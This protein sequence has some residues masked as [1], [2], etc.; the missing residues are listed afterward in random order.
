MS[1]PA[2]RHAARPT[3]RAPRRTPRATSALLAALVAGAFL[4]AAARADTF[5]VQPGDDL[6]AVLDGAT[7]EDIVRLAS[8]TYTGRFVI[9]PGKDG[10]RVEGKGKAVLDLLDVEEGGPLVGLEIASSDV[11]L[12][13]LT[14][15]HAPEDSV[16]VSATA[17]GL[18]GLVL[19]RLTILNARG[20]AID[21]A[22]DDHRVDRCT[23]V[24]ARD[25][26]VVVEGDGAV[27]TR[28]DIRQC[29]EDAVAVDGDGAE[30]SRNTI[31][32]IRGDNG[33]D[34][35][36][37]GALVS[38]NTISRTDD[39][40]VNVDGDD[41]VVD[42]NRV[43]GVVTDAGVRVQGANPSVTANRVEG[44]QNTQVG[45]SVTSL[46]GGGLVDANTVQRGTGTGLRVSGTGLTVSRNKVFDCG[47]RGFGLQLL[48]DLHVVTRNQVRRCHQ[49]GLRLDGNG[50]T[51][52]RNTIRDNHEDGLVV[53]SGD[54]TLLDRNTIRDNASE[55]VENGGTNTTLR[56]N[57]VRRNRIDVVNDT[58]GGATLVIE[59]GNT[60][61]D[62]SD[63]SASP[64]V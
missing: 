22:G 49:D 6:Q 16:A 10:L 53:G 62:G 4:P 17:L 3:P 24:G 12:R 55:G 19:E 14:L 42:R 60:I 58:D 44:V 56:A 11:T 36:G 38:R 13:N 30:I 48:G 41:A 45:L 33:V 25:S 37:A 8:G 15:R 27:I 31:A 32:D 2:R 61:G 29:E 18:S 47:V 9:G 1:Q 46:S 21:L 52:E 7:G 43:E 34:V 57:N 54:G 35:L 40:A 64:E 59:D 5:T 39:S 63:G 23:I 20:R 28:C 26:A 50:L 51:L